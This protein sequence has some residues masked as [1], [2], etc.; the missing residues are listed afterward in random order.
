MK[1]QDDILSLIA[2]NIAGLANTI[3]TAQLKKWIDDSPSNKKYFEQME[4]IWDISDSLSIPQKINTKE[5]LRKVLKRITVGTPRKTL[6]YYWQKIA[7]IIIIPFAIG[8]LL[9]IY[10]NSDKAFSSNEIAYNEIF[11]AYGTR[12]SL[13]LPD[14]TL[15]WLNSGSSLKYPN[16]FDKKSRKVFL[17][18]EAYFEV[19]SDESSPFIVQTATIM[20]KATGTKFNV[21]EYESNMFS[22]VALISGKVFVSE[23]DNVLNPQLISELSPNQHLTYNRETKIKTISNEDA[24]RFVA[25][26]EGKLIFR[27]EPLDKVLN[28]L[29]II[30]N[31]DIELQGKELHDY[32]YRATFQGESLEE[33]LKLLKLSSPI[34]FAEVKRDPLPDGS[35][36]KKKV[37]IYPANK[38]N[39]YKTN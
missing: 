39:I 28:T 26:K 20:V 9:W 15:V 10:F 2:K 32:R 38:K 8:T 14:S 21:Q 30:F 1:L 5:A 6:W 25:W 23:S 24:Y 17:Q 3:E 27:N 13:L 11:T 12:S 22:E 19:E 18:G 7:A 37:I 29:S 31:V 4:N 35:F 33:I 34:N 16:I 36:L